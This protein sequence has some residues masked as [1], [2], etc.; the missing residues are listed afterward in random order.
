MPGVRDFTLLINEQ[1]IDTEKYDFFPY[2]DK[3]IVDPFGTLKRIKQL[4][5]GKTPHDYK[6]YIFARYCTADSS[7]NQEAIKSAYKASKMFKKI[8][9]SKRKKYWKISIHYS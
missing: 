9:L 7:L 8:P 4:Q 3:M 1:E 6:D 5:N 2:S